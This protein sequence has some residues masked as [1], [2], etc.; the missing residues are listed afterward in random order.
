MAIKAGIQRDGRGNLIGSQYTF[1]GMNNIINPTNLTI[2]SG[3]V[4]DGVNVDFDNTNSATVRSGYTLAYS[5]AFHS[6]YT[7][8]TKTAAYMVSDGWIYQFDGSSPPY[9]I[10]QVS[11]NDPMEF[12]Q[13]NDVMVYSNGTDFGVIG[14]VFSQQRTY[15]P[16]F[17]ISTP[18]G[19]NL[20]FYN[21]RLYFSRENS[22]YCTDTFDVEHMD[23]RFNR[24][25]TFPH[26]ITMCKRVED[27][28]WIGTEKY[29]Y[30]LK[31]DDLIASSS[32]YEGAKGGFYQSIVAKAG[33]V[34][35]TACKTNAEYIPEAQTTNNV[36]IF[37]TTAGIC[38]GGN[39]G[40]YTN[41][42]FNEMTFDVGTRGVGFIKTDHGISQYV[43]TFDMDD[44]YEYNPYAYNLTFD[45]NT[46]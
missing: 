9:A 10:I 29:I 25:G 2:E 40:K 16:D 30:F 20:E 21:G 37:L 19:R 8:D 28:L 22:L 24:V 31:G 17:K 23:V 32:P 41:H 46:L 5:G 13:V 44:G 18:G 43:V 34:Y 45:I 38:S 39:S 7:N 11:N 6:A 3:R 26:T 12:C 42:S 27:G 4:V 1:A 36:I 14:G 15:S 33:V 35:G